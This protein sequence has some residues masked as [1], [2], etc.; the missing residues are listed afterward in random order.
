MPSLLATNQRELSALIIL[1][2]PS[3]CSTPTLHTEQPL[4][5]YN[6]HPPPRGLQPDSRDSPNP[7]RPGRPRRRSSQLFN[8]SNNLHLATRHY[9]QTDPWTPNLHPLLLPNTR[10]PCSYR[11]APASAK[12]SWTRLQWQ[13]K[14]CQRHLCVDGQYNCRY[15]S[16]QSS[17]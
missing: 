17:L 11:T 8:L 13:F 10:E 12:G 15:T 4:D 6:L 9:T 16:F 1:Q 7:Y 14:R 5:H 3:C 2:S